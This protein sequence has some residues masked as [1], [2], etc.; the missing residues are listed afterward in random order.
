M[1]YHCPFSSS[2]STYYHC[3]G[4]ARSQNFT[5]R[6]EGGLSSRKSHGG[7]T[8]RKTSRGRIS[9]ISKV[10]DKSAR[11]SARRGSNS[12]R[13]SSAL[14]KHSSARDSNAYD[15]IPVAKSKGDRGG[16]LAKTSSDRL[17]GLMT[18]SPTK[19]P[20]QSKTI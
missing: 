6:T 12:S 18:P 15:D 16:R 13:G 8:D 14:D 3:T 11:L 20:R 4:T 17:P 2:L 5:S 9:S 10:G 19:N 7:Q 1:M